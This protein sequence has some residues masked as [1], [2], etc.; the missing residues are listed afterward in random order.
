MKS[1]LHDLSFV[2]PPFSS[3]DGI[4][5]V[6]TI[7]S[8]RIL[9]GKSKKQKKT[10]PKQRTNGNDWL[11]NVPPWIKM[12]MDPIET[13]GI[14]FQCQSCWLSGNITPLKINGWN[15]LPWRIGRLFIFLSKWV[16]CRFH[17]N[18]PG[19]FR[20]QGCRSHFNFFPIPAMDTGLPGSSDWSDA[21]SRNGSCW[22]SEPVSR[23]VVAS[24]FLA[25]TSPGV[26][27]FSFLLGVL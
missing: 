24:H 27:L 23:Y 7:F 5:F 13:W 21:S 20:F 18:L 17:V 22:S 4:F 9:K 14:F 25:N 10:P 11:E 12:Y 8:L 6:G 26:P 19:C 1:W 15:I 2:F 3:T 16:I